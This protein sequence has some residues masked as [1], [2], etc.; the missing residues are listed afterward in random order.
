MQ[1][2]TTLLFVVVASCALVLI[3]YFMSGM[4]SPNP[5]REFLLFLHVAAACR[6]ALPF[7]RDDRDGGEGLSTD[8]A[9]PPAAMSILITILFSL[10]A[11]LALGALVYPYVDEWTDHRFSNEID[12]PLLG[13]MPTLV[14]VLAPFCAIVVFGWL[15]TKSWLLNNILAISLIIFFLTR[16]A[17]SP[18]LLSLCHLPKT[19]TRWL[20]LPASASPPSSSPPPSSFSPSSTT[21]SGYL[22]LPF[23][24]KILE[25][26]LPIPPT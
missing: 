13:P 17:A 14:F 4:C 23:L 10:I 7:R 15:V 3:F 11:T 6:V 12:V 2:H 22:P 8:S 16:F 9:S 19:H 21:S 18:F 1:L 25:L 5:G 20:L 26:T 24:G